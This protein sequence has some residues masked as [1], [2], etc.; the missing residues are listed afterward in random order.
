M[1]MRKPECDKCLINNTGTLHKFKGECARCE[2]KGDIVRTVM[3]GFITHLCMRCYN[4]AKVTTLGFF[5][6]KNR[7]LKAY[8]DLEEMLRPEDWEYLKKSFEVTLRSAIR[9]RKCTY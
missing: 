4:L 6:G 3:A 2:N 5:E 9:K 7:E 8:P 1:I